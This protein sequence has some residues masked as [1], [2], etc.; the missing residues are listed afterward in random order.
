MADQTPLAPPI[1]SLRWFAR[2]LV[3][4]LW[5]LGF[6]VVLI[7]VDPVPRLLVWWPLGFAAVVF[8]CAAYWS[9]RGRT[10]PRTRPWLLANVGWAL[11]LTGYGLGR[12]AAGVPEDQVGMG[13]DVLVAIA[14]QCALAWGCTS[15]LA[16]EPMSRNADS[17]GPT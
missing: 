9:L 12:I 11:L 13:P 10:T 7:W 6:A 2:L 17:A 16:D 5:L 4:A 8:G 1:L 15:T 14:I 3:E